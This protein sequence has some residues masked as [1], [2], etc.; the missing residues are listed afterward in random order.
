MN[1][2][3]P[4]VPGTTYILYIYPSTL[5]RPVGYSCI[6]N[7]DV[8][9][10][11]GILFPFQEGTEESFFVFILKIA[12]LSKILPFLLRIMYTHLSSSGSGMLKV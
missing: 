5:S 10:V 9:Q 6:R 11:N 12:E 2:N 8:L 1:I 4:K 3:A 7:L